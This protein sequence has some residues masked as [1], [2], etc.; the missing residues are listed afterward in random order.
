MHTSAKFTKLKLYNALN[1]DRMNI[2][3]FPIGAAV[4]KQCGSKVYDIAV[5][6]VSACPFSQNLAK[7]A[8]AK[9][10]ES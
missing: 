7:M 4:L 9:F 2:K 8:F 1:V 3:C 6:K 5:H 10:M